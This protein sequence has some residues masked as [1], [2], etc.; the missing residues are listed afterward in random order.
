MTSRPVA[1]TFAATAFLAAALSSAGCSST[2]S[3]NTTAKAAATVPP[4]APSASAVD[5][6]QAWCLGGNGYTDLQEVVSDINQIRVDIDNGQDGTATQDGQKL[7]EDAQSAQENLPPE[8]DAGQVQYARYMT[9]AGDAGQQF[10]ADNVSAA[11][12]HIVQA[13]KFKKAVQT[14]SDKCQSE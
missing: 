9:Q 14:A 7:V 2:A 12:P 10:Y 5:P 3:T 4:A 13:A 11:L 1:A 8:S 6:W